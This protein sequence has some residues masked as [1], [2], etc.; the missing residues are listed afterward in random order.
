MTEMKTTLS[1]SFVNQWCEDITSCYDL[2]ETY[3]KFN[4]NYFNGE[5]PVLPTVTLS[6][7]AGETWETTKRIKWDGRMK[8]SWGTYAPNGKGSGVIKLAKMCATV[9]HQTYSTLLHELIH[10]YLDFRNEDDGINGHGANF[11]RK[12]KE[13]N[14]KC[15][16][17]KVGYRVYYDGE[18]ITQEAAEFQ[19][20]LLMSSFTFDDLDVAK[21]VESVINGAF[22]GSYEYSQ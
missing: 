7:E 4:A 22:A 8:K 21:K 6:N 15:E 12:A 17:K 11:I 3:S 16:D 1:N 9:P 5:L 10:A 19:V 20:P 2:V 13:I 14:E 18:V